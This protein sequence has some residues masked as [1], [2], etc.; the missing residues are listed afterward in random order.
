MAH[1]LIAEERERL[2]VLK[3]QGKNQA[4]I[5]RC[6]GRDPSTISRELRRNQVGDSYS[7]VAAQR[8]AETR[9]CQRPLTPK[10]ERPDINDY[11]RQGLVKYWSPEQIAGRLRQDFPN[12]PRH[13]V[14]HQTIY[15]W[16]DGDQCRDHWEQFLRHRGRKRSEP[17]KR[18]QI[19]DP[20]S[21]ADRP[22]AANDRSRFGDWEGDTVVS[23]GRQGG[24]V[25]LVERRS[26]Y[27]LIEKTRDRTA[28]TTT[29]A[30]C[31]SLDDFP[32]ELRRTMTLDRGKEF[33]NHEILADFLGLDVYFADPYAAW[34]RGTVENTNGLLRQFFPK[35]T[36][37]RPVRHSR[38]QEAQALLNNR[39]RKCLDFRT[40]AEVL[41][42]HLGCCI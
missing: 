12:D 37:F 23:C 27:T 6:L 17:E 24:V 1:Q 36:D 15:A 9:R 22:A 20:V 11:V 7:A 25:T 39:P 14:S 29:I 40:P 4:E 2:C 38:L 35:G 33:A 42:Q 41:G 26:R 5:A 31:V 18:G 19:V 10:M 28:K 34:Q 13:H 32:P 8:R 3:A 30:I 16:I 21:V